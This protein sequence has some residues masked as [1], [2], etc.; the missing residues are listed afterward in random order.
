[1]E[2]RQY[3]SG[4][5]VRVQVVD[6][7]QGMNQATL[8]RIFEPFFTTKPAGS[9]T[10]LGLSIAHSIIVQ[11]GG[12]ITAR[13]EVGQGTCFEILLPS[14][15]TFQSCL[16]PSAWGDP[17]A[18]VLL[19]EDEDKVRRLMHTYLERS[20]FQLLEARNAEEAALIAEVYPEPIHILVADV[21]MPGVSGP[22][23]AERLQP[24][25]PEM[26]VLFVSGY[27]HDAFDHEGI[28]KP[29][30]EILSKPF[31]APELVRRV[32]VLLGQQPVGV[33]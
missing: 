22:Q 30:A 21:V 25:R 10:G 19:V 28:H 15:G 17:P 3:R 23:L 31:P 16:G 14:L 13:S 11:A 1:M 27:R 9:G 29:G 18:T 5:Y 32:R 8:A 12:Y 7:G 4:S 33:N 6:Q 24:L 26:K 2:T 20:G